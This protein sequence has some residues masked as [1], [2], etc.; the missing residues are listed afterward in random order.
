MKNLKKSI[1]LPVILTILF[2]G[3]LSLYIKK[4]DANQPNTKWNQF[5]SGARYTSPTTPPTEFNSNGHYENYILGFS[6]D[7][8]EEIFSKSNSWNDLTGKTFFKGEEI[9]PILKVQNVTQDWSNSYDSC[10]KTKEGGIISQN[11]KTG[12][13]VKLAN[14]TNGCVVAMDPRGLKDGEPSWSYIA[15][16]RQGTKFL[17]IGIS[18][19]DKKDLETL[20][21][22]FNMITA[23]FKFIASTQ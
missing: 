20:T 22:H 11:A 21:S 10:I 7:Y 9:S 6:F 18:T 3:C 2:L 4:Q 15:Y 14:T 8:P 19:N 16:F 5:I 1:T 23:S 17:S 12:T 13:S